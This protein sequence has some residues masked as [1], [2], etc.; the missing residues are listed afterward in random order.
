[1]YRPKFSGDEYMLPAPPFPPPPIV[2]VGSFTIVAAGRDLPG[3]NTSMVD[4]DT[5]IDSTAVQ[6]LG[7]VM[8][9]PSPTYPPASATSSS[10]RADESRLN[11]EASPAAAAMTAD[12]LEGA[13]FAARIARRSAAFGSMSTTRAPLP[14]LGVQP[15]SHCCALPPNLSL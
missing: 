2:K 12:R 9:N 15:M 3:A 6:P 7:K 5:P 4:L 8:V 11:T 1:M 10:A 14:A 13:S